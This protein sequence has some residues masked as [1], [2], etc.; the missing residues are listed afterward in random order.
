MPDTPEIPKR[1]HSRARRLRMYTI[2][3]IDHRTKAHRRAKAAAAELVDALGGPKAI[4]QAQ[5]HACERAGMWVAVSEDLAARR[6]AGFPG[7]PDELFRA[8]GV[9]RR[10]VQAVLASKSDPEPKPTERPGLAIARR[11][12]A[13]N[14]ARAATKKDDRNAS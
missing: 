5:R 6:L 2:D 1:Q 13:E 3:D 9:A 11:R 4:T 12:W 8:E 10:A 7:D 14:A